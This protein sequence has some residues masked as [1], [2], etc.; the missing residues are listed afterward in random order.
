METGDEETDTINHSACN[1]SY[2]RNTLGRVRALSY[3]RLLRLNWLSVRLSGGYHGKATLHIR[4]ALL[5]SPLAQVIC[6]VAFDL[7]PNLWRRTPRESRLITGVTFAG[8]IDVTEAFQKPTSSTPRLSRFD[9][10]TLHLAL[11]KIH[12]YFFFG[13]ILMRIRFFPSAQ[14]FFFLW[15]RW[16]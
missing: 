6:F 7:L 13:E 9:M 4:I 5:R 10:F 3:S 16:N 15:A 12:A 14:S 8:R 11:I 1:I 2:T